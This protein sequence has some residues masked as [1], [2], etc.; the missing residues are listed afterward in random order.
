ME[1][2]PTPPKDESESSYVT[3]DKGGVLASCATS[4]KLEVI[5]VTQLNNIP[6]H[7]PMY[8]STLDMPQHTEP[9][10]VFLNEMIKIKEINKSQ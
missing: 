4:L 7:M 2:T 3:H 9:Y 10:R 5:K 1:H 6:R 8:T